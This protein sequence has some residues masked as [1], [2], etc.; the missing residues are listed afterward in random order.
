[1]YDK[2]S[3][4]VMEKKAYELILSEYLPP[5]SD[6]ILSQV[7]KFNIPQKLKCFIWLAF[8]K[9]K[10]TLDNPCKRGWLGPNRCSL[11]KTDVESIDH[12]FVGCPFA[13]EVLHNLGNIFDVHLDW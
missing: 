9:K 5:S 12:M 3:G 10:N 1:M 11:C 6:C 7:W 8:N 4:K 13:Q 2:K